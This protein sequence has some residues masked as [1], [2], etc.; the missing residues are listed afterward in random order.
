MLAVDTEP[1]PPPVV[2]ATATAASFVAADLFAG[3][4]GGAVGIFIGQPFDFVK[5]RLQT[6]GG[7]RYTSVWDCVAQ[8]IRE[9]LGLEPT[10][11]L[12]PSAAPRT[13]RS[14]PRYCAHS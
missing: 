13:Q 4:F 3:G 7:S 12:D 6:L 14:L 9:L 8:S 10:D 11:W 5:V 1:S 2:L